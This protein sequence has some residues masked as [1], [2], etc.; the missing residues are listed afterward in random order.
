MSYEVLA[1]RWRPQSFQDVVGQAHVITTLKNQ[2]LSNRIGHA[3]LFWGPRGTGKTTVA[4]ILAKAVNCLNRDAETALSREATAEPCN[5]CGSC[6]EISQGRSF[7]VIEMDAASNRGI[8]P[9]RELR[10]NVKLA[11]SACRYKIYIIDEAH[12]LTQEAFNALLKTLEE[13][14][15]HVIFILATTERHKIPKTILSRCQDFDFRHMEEEQVI[16]RL[17]EIADAEEL[18]IDAEV[19]HLIARQ[20]EG[21][22]RDAQNLLERLTASAGKK[23]DIEAVNGILGLSSSHLLLEL[24]EAIL[25]SQLPKA[26]QVLADL[27]KQGGDLVQVLHQLI[28]HFSNLRRLAIDASL[29]TLIHASK[30]EIAFLATQANAASPERLSRIIR[31][32]MRT[33]SSIKQHGYAQI[34]FESALV[35]MCSIQEGIQLSRILRRLA[36]IE[37]KIDRGGVY[38]KSHMAS[39][40]IAEEFVPSAPGQLPDRGTKPQSAEHPITKPAVQQ[41]QPVN[42]RTPALMNQ[43]ASNGNA[44]RAVANIQHWVDTPKGLQDL[45]KQVLERLGES[46]KFSLKT[47]LTNAR[48]LLGDSADATV[49]TFQLACPPAFTDTMNE[50]EKTLLSEILS[51]LVGNSVQVEFV[52]ASATSSDE[53]IPTSPRRRNQEVTPMMQQRQARQDVLLSP[54]L[55]LFEA[56]IIKIELK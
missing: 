31:I 52:A 50:E 18:D 40:R 20:S 43:S 2:I 44:A 27:S 19:L 4:R 24:T 30:S 6:Q 54:T 36:E 37:D 42:A 39:K 23:L 49:S 14:P 55:D 28:G 11:P 35:D 13:P 17:Q 15:P 45:W 8:D 34:Q 26:V 51:G 56:E 25:S 53:A 7:D 29:K 38:V 41:T 33:V 32:L 3:Y 48:L 47:L 21:C 22:L 10:E 5:Q 1:Q 9:I 16:G 46:G 12:M